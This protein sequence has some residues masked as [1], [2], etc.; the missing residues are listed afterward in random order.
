[1]P[2]VYAIP[3]A[4]M[5]AGHTHYRV[6]VGGGAGF[7]WSKGL[8]FS[9]ITDGTSNTW[10]VV[11]AAD[12]VPWTKPDEL[13]Y[14]AKMPLPRFGDFHGGK[15]FQVLFFDGSV[16]SINLNEPEARLRAFIT[17]TANDVPGDR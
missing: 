3:S 8:K 4:P 1:M 15:L 11:E 2:P 17:R 13:V 9:D 7:E 6:F 10:A 5:A 12:S 14:D 16:H